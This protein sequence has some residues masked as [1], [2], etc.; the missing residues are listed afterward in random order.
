MTPV[1]GKI[2]RNFERG[3]LYIMKKFK[4]QINSVLLLIMTS[5]QGSFPCAASITDKLTST[6]D[7]KFQD[8]QINRLHYNDID[9]T[10]T[11]SLK[12]ITLDSSKN[13]KL[14][15][16]TRQTAGIGTHKRKWRS[17]V[18]GNIYASLS[19]PHKI[20]FRDQVSNQHL[21]EY[22]E[23]VYPFPQIAALSVFYV[24][25]R[26]SQGKVVKFKWPNDVI[27]EQKKIS[28]ILVNMESL[29]EEANLFRCIIGFGLNVNMPK[30]ILD[31]IDQPA[32]SM[33]IESGIAFDTEEILE[34]I[35]SEFVKLMHQYKINK[36]GFFLNF[37]TIWLL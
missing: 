37:I 22:A 35:L 36:R 28:G 29:P 18:E 10:Q 7:Y 14:V 11:Y 13:W 3:N 34:S 8:I 33:Q 26:N 6:K 16:A 31:T 15:T 1:P 12:Y 25:Q 30:E 19:L 20:E 32:T 5:F 9:S 2:T 24:V 21:E 27:V 17:D 4:I 23:N